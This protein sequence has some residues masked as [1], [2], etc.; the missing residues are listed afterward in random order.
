MIKN[1]FNRKKP[2]DLLVIT[3]LLVPNVYNENIIFKLFCFQQKSVHILHLRNA[4]IPN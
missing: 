2:C 4:E 3:A 1:I